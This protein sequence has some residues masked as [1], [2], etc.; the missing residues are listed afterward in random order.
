MQLKYE[1]V[2][3]QSVANQIA[4]QIRRAIT[5]GTLESR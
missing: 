2:V 5:N 4:E 1:P 3:T